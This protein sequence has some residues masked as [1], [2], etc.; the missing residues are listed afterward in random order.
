MWEQMT[1]LDILTTTPVLNLDD[2]IF[3]RCLNKL[4]SIV[5]TMHITMDIAHPCLQTGRVQCILYCAGVDGPGW[6]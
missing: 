3:Y 2:A 1:H 4:Q 5:Q 6:S